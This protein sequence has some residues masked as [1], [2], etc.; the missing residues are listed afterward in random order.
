M[1]TMRVV[2]ILSVAMIYTAACNLPAPAEPLP[3]NLQTAAALTVEAVL[4]PQNS[5][6]PQATN[7]SSSQA[8][9]LLSLEDAVNCRSGPGTNYKIISVLENISVPIVGKDPGGGYWVVDPPDSDENCWVRSDFGTVNGGTADVPAITP[10]PGTAS[11]VP[12]R[13]SNFFY[14]YF[15]SGGDI[16]TTLSWGDA[17]DNE[18]GYRIY[19]YD[20]LVVDLPANSTQYQDAISVAAGTPLQYSVVAYNDAGESPPRTANFTC[21]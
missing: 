21:Q 9:A 1:K 6:V 4:T 10:V 5:P 14:N 3:Q 11:D 19:R 20:Q 12:A 15:C 2:T 8:A 7:A 18:N 13:P 16:T 17:A